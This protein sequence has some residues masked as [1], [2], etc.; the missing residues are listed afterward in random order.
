MMTNKNPMV[1]LVRLPLRNLGSAQP[2]ELDLTQLVL[3]HAYADEGDA[4]N[5]INAMNTIPIVV[6]KV[7]SPDTSHESDDEKPYHYEVIDGHHIFFALQRAQCTW[8]MCL[9]LSETES[10][11]D[12]WKT[13]LG[14]EPPK[15]NLCSIKL[16]EVQQHKDLKQYLEQIKHK[17]KA[18]SKLNVDLL[19]KKLAEDP[20][21]VY[22]E[23]LDQLTLFKGEV[24]T[25]NGKISRKQIVN[26]KT[27]D[28]LANYLSAKPEPLRPLEKL[29][30]NT[31]PQEALINQFKR[32]WMEPEGGGLKKLGLSGLSRICEAI[33]ADAGRPYWRESKDVTA[34]IKDLPGSKNHLAAISKGFQFSPM[35]PPI[36]NTVR[37][38]LNRMTTTQLR[39]EA[40]ARGIEHKAIRTKAGLID[41]LCDPG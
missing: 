4:M 26:K 40:T 9:R 17:E 35:D 1:D 21:R 8:A 30:I 19:V 11:S 32:L 27:R 34:S 18:L 22:W 16:E 28:I 10:A 2:S 38:L 7:S 13:E 29:C 37:F 39:K 15:L 20:T 25:G 41:A 14:I 33:I 6:K 5:T 36:P 3:T 24:D 23:S 12:L 31:A